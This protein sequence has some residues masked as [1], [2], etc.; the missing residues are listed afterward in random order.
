MAFITCNSVNDQKAERNDQKGLRI[1]CDLSQTRSMW[2]QTDL[3]LFS[4]DR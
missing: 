1:F 4:T 3:S 2:Q